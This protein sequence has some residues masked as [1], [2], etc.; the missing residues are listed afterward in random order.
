MVD[1]PI[2]QAQTPLV[3]ARQRT[4]RAQKRRRQDVGQAT[5]DDAAWSLTTHDEAWALL[6]RIMSATL[7]CEEQNVQRYLVVERCVP[8]SHYW[9]VPDV[10]RVPEAAQRTERQSS[11]R[12]G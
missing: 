11:D 12:R 1:H 8:A 9:D 6:A 2:R 3:R 10:S 5:G 4:N 7:A